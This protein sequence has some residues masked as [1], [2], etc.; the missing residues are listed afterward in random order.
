MD[1]LFG[2]MTRSAEFSPCRTWRYSLIRQWD[3][4]LPV[5]VFVLLNPSVADEFQD[6][7]TNRRGINFANSWGYGSCI[8]VNLFAIRS[9]DPKIIKQADDPIGPENDSFII[10]WA[11]RADI[12]VC[13]WGVH[14]D[15]EGR[16]SQVRELLSNYQVNHLGLT[17]H[18]HPKH[19]LYLKADLKPTL[20]TAPKE[21]S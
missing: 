11:E 21:P 7:P 1:D 9:P 15:Y 2:G 19:P 20:W 5:A 12:L 3:D 13:G 17:K 16:D 18:G 10:A 14:G 6:D 8:F 4:S